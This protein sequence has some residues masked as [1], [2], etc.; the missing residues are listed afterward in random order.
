VL[1]SPYQG[2]MPFTGLMTVG[3]NFSHLAEEVAVRFLLYKV[4]FSVSVLSFLKEVTTH[5]LYLKSGELCTTSSRVASLPN[6]T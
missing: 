1:F 2:H 5:N 6:A 3:I 4:T